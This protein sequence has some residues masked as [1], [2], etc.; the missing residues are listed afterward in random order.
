MIEIPLTQSKMAII[1]EQD[2]GLVGMH[3]WSAICPHVTWY[4]VRTSPRPS[5]DMIY[6]H[7]VIMNT[8]QR[9]DHWDHDGLN[10]RRS[11]LRV[12]SQT[13]NLGNTIKRENTT[14]RYKG[15]SWHRAGNKWMAQIRFQSSRA[16]LGSFVDEKD[17]ALAYNRAAQEL[18]GEF[19]LLNDIQESTCPNFSVLTSQTCSP[20]IRE[21]ARV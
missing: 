16:Y 2:F 15:V 7:R 17:A 21:A 5:R 3:K 11:N 10:N 12:C 6:M 8:N 1:D 20:L 19:A 18:F 14:S 9:V 4:A 13:Q